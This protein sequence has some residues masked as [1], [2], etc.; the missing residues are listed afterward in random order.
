LEKNLESSNNIAVLISGK[1]RTLENLNEKI[2]AGSLNVNIKVVIASKKNIPGIDVAKKYAN[3]LEIV[4]RKNFNTIWEFSEAVFKILNQFS[5][6][7]VVL[8]GWI[9]KLY[10]PSEYNFRV[11]NIHPALLPLFGGW[12]YYGDF[13]HKAVIESKM[14]FS[15]CTV[16]YVTNEYDSGPI[17][18]QEIVAVEENDTAESLAH[19]VFEKEKELYPKAIKFVLSLQ[20]KQQSS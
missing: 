7:L 2:L 11:I 18:M 1:G 13:V 4:E 5:L 16:H 14:K 8:A 10:I 19:K 12:L 20:R 15:G 17:I 6:Q 9:H 3:R